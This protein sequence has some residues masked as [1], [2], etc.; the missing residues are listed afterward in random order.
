[1]MYFQRGLSCWHGTKLTYII[2]GFSAWVQLARKW[3]H[4]PV[5]RRLLYCKYNGWKCGPDNHR[6]PTTK[7]YPCTENAVC[8]ICKRSSRPRQLC[9][10]TNSTDL[11]YQPTFIY[12]LAIWPLTSCTGS[13]YRGWMREQRLQIYRAHG[14]RT[15]WVHGKWT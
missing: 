14:F 5:L 4:N 2:A 10:F 12:C 11:G 9:S 1:M 3:R 6:A 8:W 7:Q 13:S 15:A